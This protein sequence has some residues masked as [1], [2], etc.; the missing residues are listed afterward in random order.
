MPAET[1]SLSQLLAFLRPGVALTPASAKKLAWDLRKIAKRCERF[2]S[3]VVEHHGSADAPESVPGA[4]KR[5]K[6]FDF[7]RF[8]N[9][10]VAF[11]LMYIGW[12]YHGFTLQDNIPNTVEASLFSALQKACL[13]RPGLSNKEM[14]YTRCGRTDIGV[15]ALANVVTLELRSK[16]SKH[17]PLPAPE[18]ELDYPLLLNQILPDDIQ[19]TGWTPVPEDCNARFSATYRQYKYFFSGTLLVP[20]CPQL[21]TMNT[22]G[23]SQRLHTHLVF[24]VACPP[25]QPGRCNNAGA[26]T[27]CQSLDA[28][29]MQTAANYL[30]GLHDFQ[31]FCKVNFSNTTNH[32]REILSAQVLPHPL[33]MHGN[34]EVLELVVRGSGFLWHQVQSLHVAAAAPEPSHVLECIKYD[35]CHT[36]DAYCECITCSDVILCS[37]QHTVWVK[38]TSPHSYVKQPFHRLNS[39]T[40]IALA[41]IQAH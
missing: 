21:P 22:S 10:Y 32:Q 34:E 19:I 18:E 11:R 6:S 40:Q 5:K 31:H 23:L 41:A 13:I 39:D 1:E 27:G 28:H 30:V 2:A 3:G 29:A 26:S 15:S 9:R 20:T 33:K 12:R 17:E 37:L 4:V 25:I 35:T 36:L 14:N 24:G 16:A 38:R 8:S 7:D